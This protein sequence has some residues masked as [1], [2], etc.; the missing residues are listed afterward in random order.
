MRTNADEGEVMSKTPHKKTKEEIERQI[1]QIEKQLIGS[2][3][4]IEMGWQA[5]RITVLPPNASQIQLEEMRVAF[6]AGAQHLF[7]TIMRT[8]DPGTDP[9]AADLNRIELID[10][11]LHDWVDEIKLRGTATKGRA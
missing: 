5:L 3:R 7:A 4:L 1:E 6:F 11:E 2:G 9:T 8:L 10:K